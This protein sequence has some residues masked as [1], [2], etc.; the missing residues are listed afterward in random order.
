MTLS[1]RKP[2]RPIN[3]PDTVYQVEKSSLELLR[4]Y[5][6]EEWEKNLRTWLDAIET[7]KSRYARERNMLR[8]PLTLATGEK[9]DLS[10]GGQNMLI[11]EIIEPWWKFR[12]T[13]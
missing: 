11:K 12:S 9:I 10:P 13:L 2:S 1:T 4:T 5:G 7:F 3:S 8:I 6:S